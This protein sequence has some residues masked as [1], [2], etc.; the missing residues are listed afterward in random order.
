[1]QP[2]ATDQIRFVTKTDSVA[3]QLRDDILRGVLGPG[4]QLEQDEV[5]RRF[6]VSSTPVR[7]AFGLLE[8]EGLLERRPHRGV[9][10]AKLDSADAEDL[11][12]VRR[13]IE[14]KAVRRVI[15]RVDQELI[16]HLDATVTAAEAELGLRRP[17]LQKFRDH[18]HHFHEILVDATGSRVFSAITRV[19][20]QLTRFRYGL[21]RKR[22]NETIRD[23][24]AM[25]EALKERDL[26]TITEVLEHHL[27]PEILLRDRQVEPWVLR[28]SP[29]Q[30]PRTRRR[31]TRPRASTA[32]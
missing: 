19:I 13:L 16:K 15:A 2:V 22:M 8:S 7:E 9:V 4:T 11:W 18:C 24:R 25:L 29:P 3:E 26:S 30:R 17:D 20:L 28:D 14:L 21:D 23:H 1:M 10:V 32:R 12:E 6:G 5:A 31:P 27:D